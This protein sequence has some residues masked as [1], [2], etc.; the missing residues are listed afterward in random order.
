[1]STQDVGS[2]QF[3][4]LMS[5]LESSLSLWGMVP[6]AFHHCG[7]EEPSFY[8][9]PPPTDFQALHQ[10]HS[11]GGGTA[12]CVACES[13]PALQGITTHTKTLL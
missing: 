7:K 4:P 1:M 11:L 3:L 5:V 12:L 2:C 9:T 10:E 6:Y 8:L 13:N